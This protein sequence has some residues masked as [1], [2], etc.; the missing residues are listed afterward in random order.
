MTKFSDFKF[1]SRTI[2]IGEFNFNHMRY[3]TYLL[4]RKEDDVWFILGE[5][6]VNV[7]LDL[8][9]TTLI[10]EDINVQLKYYKIDPSKSNSK[11][12]FSFKIGAVIRFTPEIAFA[13]TSVLMFFRNITF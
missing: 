13:V 7:E 12:T 5:V 1:L 9:I 2:K 11:W 3:G 6:K 10:I 4:A 8:K